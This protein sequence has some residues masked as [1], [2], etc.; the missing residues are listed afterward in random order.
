MTISDIHFRNLRISFFKFLTR[1]FAKT[2]YAQNKIIH[3]GE[4]NIKLQ[5][6]NVR[7]RLDLGNSCAVNLTQYYKKTG[8][9]SPSGA[10]NNTTC[11]EWMPTLINFDEID[12][13]ALDQRIIRI[14]FINKEMVN[15]RYETMQIGIWSN[16]KTDKFKHKLYLL[17]D[18]IVEILGKDTIDGTQKKFTITNWDDPEQQ[19][20][21]LGG[22]PP[23]DM[24]AVVHLK[25]SMKKPPDSQTGEFGDVLSL[26]LISVD[27]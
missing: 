9:T 26:W 11:P 7:C 22:R 1:E 16:K 8:F 5:T 4:P 10:C 14:D 24:E 18:V 19:P 17:R 23:R 3:R 20:P 12:Y 2:S 27:C 21:A 13:Q 15:S 6:D 25:D